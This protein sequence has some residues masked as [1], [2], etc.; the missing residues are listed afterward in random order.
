MMSLFHA[1]LI[2]SRSVPAAGFDGS[3][4]AFVTCQIVASARPAY[5]PMHSSAAAITTANAFPKPRRSILR[6]IVPAYPPPTVFGSYWNQEEPEDMPPAPY[7]VT[8]PI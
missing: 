8:Y 6:I 1:L 4:A 7:S 5:P 2:A 3:S